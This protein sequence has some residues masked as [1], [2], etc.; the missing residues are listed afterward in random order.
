MQEPRHSNTFQYIERKIIKLGY[1]ENMRQRNA[2]YIPLKQ[3]LKSLLESDL[4][5]N[6]QLQP[7]SETD[8]CVLGDICDGKAFKSHQFFVTNPGGLRLI[9]YQDSFEVVNPLGSARKAHKV[10]AVYLSVANLHVHVWSNTDH[11]SL[12]LLCG[13]ND[14]KTFGCAKVFAE[15]LAD[16]KDF[17]ENG[18][19]VGG[20]TVKGA[21]YC[22]AGDNLGSHSIGG[23]T[24][25]FTHSRYFCR[26][27]EVTR[28]E[29][30]KDPNLCEQPRTIETYDAAVTSL[31][32][33]SREVRG[34]KQRSVFNDLPNF[35][36]CQPGLP[37]CLGH[38]IFERVLSYDLA[39]Y[40]KYFSKK[41][42]WFTYT[43]LNRRI[44]QF[45]YKG[46]DALSKPCTVKS[47]A[48]K[49]SGHAVQNWNFLRLLPVL[50]GDKVQNEDDD[51]WQLT[52]MAVKAS[53]RYCGH[54]LC[55]KNVIVPGMLSKSIWMKESVCFLKVL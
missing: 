46:S 44:K 51:V 26:Y 1:D 8:A 24:E 40:L 37:P 3:T 21:L 23:Y 16:L 45:K 18:V 31:S 48:L 30:Q 20:E 22:I 2:Y 9:L 27:C 32:E 12:V 39:L 25:N 38:N 54:G 36:V 4:W 10:L 43:L 19:T 42:K 47:G 50:I 13:E 35:H 17:E 33:E 53:Q 15:I 14:L 34:I 52:L 49:L 28:E 29:F 55:T 11:M 41:R 7:T 5:K 6:S